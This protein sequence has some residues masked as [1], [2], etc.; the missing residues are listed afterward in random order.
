VSTLAAKLDKAAKSIMFT[1]QSNRV[2]GIPLS[3][4]P[5]GV[6]TLPRT[7]SQ[8]YPAVLLAL[9]VLLGMED[10]YLSTDRTR[11]IQN[12]LVGLYMVWY[13]LKRTWLDRD[14]LEK[15]PGLIHRCVPT[16]LRNHVRIMMS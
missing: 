7:K 14:E 10:K 9:M 6:T 15:L 11:A 1:H 13:V 12:V 2:S 4:F 3:N 16:Q 5:R 8:E